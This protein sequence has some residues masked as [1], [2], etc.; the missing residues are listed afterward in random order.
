MH[1][2]VVV[3]AAGEGKRMK[4]SRPKVVHE[5]CGQPLLKYVITEV[6]KLAPDRLIFV[7]GH[8]SEEVTSL[9]GCEGK[10]VIQSEQMG[11]AHAVGVAEPQLKDVEGTIMV[12]C[13]DAPLI[14]HE[15]LRELM[16]THKK[17]KAAATLLSAHLPNPTGY[18]RIIRKFGGVVN[19]IVE[20]K[21]ATE[22]EKKICEINSGF[23]CF[24]KR[25]LFAALN[26][27]NCLNAQGEFYLTD[28][29]EILNKSGKKVA[30][31]MAKDGTE[32]SGVNSRK[33]LAQ[34]QQVMQ[35]RINE[36]LMENGVTI[37]APDLT[38]IGPQVEVG[39][40]TVIY[41]FSII[42]GKTKIGKECHLGPSV[43]LID[44]DVGDRVKMENIVAEGSIIEDEV[45]LG[46]FCRLRS[47]TRVKK[48]AKIGSYVELKKSEVGEGS[49]VPHLSYIGDAIIGKDVNVGAGTITCNYDGVEKHQTIIEDGAFVGSDTM[50]VAPVKVGKN[51]TIG[52]GS[53]INADVPEDSLALE[54]TE[55]R[56][57]KSWSRKKRSRKNSK[58]Q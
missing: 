3:L 6:K 45:T 17:A 30:V 53:T 20:E 33:E 23:Y 41:P 14:Q 37:I 55:Q 10:V 58:G 1:L 24:E 29:I 51:A 25:E 9:V 31:S 50:L 39:R 28:V 40:D 12:T 46:P 48:G 54:R 4:S 34:A 42:E 44:M 43:H 26:K 5:I 15:T 13:G 8:Q 27:I 18:G 2:A 35:A 21:D 16:K 56:I 32:I 11:T 57:I 38:F 19:R 7:L 36:R 52:A 47:G 22:E 49:K